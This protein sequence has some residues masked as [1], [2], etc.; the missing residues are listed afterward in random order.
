MMNGT[1]RT[2]DV[3]RGYGYIDPDDGSGEVLVHRS[4]VEQAGL[5]VLAPGQR[6]EFELSP[7]QDEDDR[8][9]SEHAK[10]A[11]RRCGRFA[12]ELWPL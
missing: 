11:G 8:Q 10:E 5:D 9:M 2:Y 12:E 4:A 7:S 6:I 3:S 1:V